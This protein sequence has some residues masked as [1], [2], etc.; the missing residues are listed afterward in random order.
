MRP[1]NDL[2]MIKRLEHLTYKERLK[3]LALIKLGKTRFRR[4]ISMGT[5][6]LM[7]VEVKMETDSSQW[8]LVIGQDAVSTH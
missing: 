5:K 3:E 7:G 6:C 8:Y 2:K 4:D 1:A